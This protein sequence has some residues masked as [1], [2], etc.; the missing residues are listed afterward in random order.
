MPLKYDPLNKHFSELLSLYVITLEA[1]G[2][3]ENARVLEWERFVGFWVG[4][5]IPQSLNMA[6]KVKHLPAMQESRVWS[7]GREDHLE[8][9]M[10]THSSTLAWKIPW[11][12]EPGG[13]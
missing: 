11:T 6:Q 2:S 8:K 5:L 3:M 1:L 13:L 4:Y 12:Q 9:E 10:A 7:L